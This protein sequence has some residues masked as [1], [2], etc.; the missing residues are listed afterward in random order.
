[1]NL[2]QLW[3]DIN[4]IKKLIGVDDS[5]ALDLINDLLSEISW[6]SEQRHYI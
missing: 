3:K 1:M 5:K 6:N 4:N 2:E